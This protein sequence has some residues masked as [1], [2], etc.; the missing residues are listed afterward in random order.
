METAQKTLKERSGYYQA[1]NDP[2]EL[3]IWAEWKSKEPDIPGIVRTPTDWDSQRAEHRP[4]RNWALK[5]LVDDALERDPSLRA[6][7][8][9]E[10]VMERIDAAKLKYQDKGKTNLA[11]KVVRNSGRVFK[12]LESLPQ[13]MPCDNGLGVLWAGLGFVFRTLGERIENRETILETLGDIPATLADATE[14]WKAYPSDAQLKMTMVN[15]YET[16]IVVVTR[17]VAI[18]LHEQPGSWSSRLL[19]R[20]PAKEADGV[21]SEIDRLSEAIREVTLR[22]EA[23]DRVISGETHKNVSDGLLQVKATRR[24]VHEVKSEVISVGKDVQS[25]ES[26]I[27]QGLEE[28][29]EL[30]QAGNQQGMDKLQQAVNDMPGMIRSVVMQEIRALMT[31]NAKMIPASLEELASHVQTGIYRI[32]VDKAHTQS[33]QPAL[34]Y[35]TTTGQKAMGVTITRDEFLKSLGVHHLQASRDIKRILRESHSLDENA[36][37]HARW[38]MTT[39]AFSSWMSSP[40]SRLIL[41]NGHCAQMS[42][43]KTTPMSA[44]CAT[45]ATA[46]SKPSSATIPL[47]FFCSEHTRSSSEAIRG[48]SGLMRSLIAQL[49]VYMEDMDLS[50]DF[51][52]APILKAVRERQCDIDRL[53]SIFRGLF[54]QLPEGVTVYVVVDG[55]SDFEQPRFLA[56]MEAAVAGLRA[57]IDWDAPGNP[58]KAKLKVLLSSGD[59][60]VRIFRGVRQRDVVSLLSGNTSSRSLKVQAV[61]EDLT[62]L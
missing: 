5:S 59:R 11:R 41:V 52:D 36:L 21:K 29:R 12:A 48:P 27:K 50:L 30:V 38:L 43:V 18:L 53:V 33:L 17:L 61:A 32:V 9:R 46:L 4:P 39:S 42:G 28:T 1:L 19:S 34:Q 14:T 44:F 7:C 3:E 31:E 49:L 55:V 47:H 20:Y 23:L 57:V 37:G 40:S 26:T 10:V 2:K 54:A 62:R 13:F 56:G 24:T 22:V 60:S 8:T 51:L 15:L 35:S 25:M 6:E 58:T 45:L 16:A